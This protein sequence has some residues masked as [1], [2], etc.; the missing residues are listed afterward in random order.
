MR[1][2][3]LI[4]CALLSTAACT[5]ATTDPGTDPTPESVSADVA[6]GD[7]VAGESIDTA[8]DV[9][10]FTLHGPAGTMVEVRPRRIGGGTDTLEF[11]IGTAV[12]Q[13]LTPAD[14]QY[15]ARATTPVAIP[16][17]GGLSILF[18]G[19]DGST[20]HSTGGYAFTVVAI[21]S[22][23]EAHAGVI[24]LIDT[25][26]DESL[27]TPGDVDLFRVHLTGPGTGFGFTFAV[28]SSALG[29]GEAIAS[30]RDSATG[31]VFVSE[32]AS[33]GQTASSGIYGL[34][35]G[36]YQVRVSGAIT[37]RYRLVTTGFQLGPEI[38]PDTVL[39]GDTVSNETISPAADI[40]RFA[41]LGTA[42]QSVLI[43]FTGTGAA[44]PGD[45]VHLMFYPKN[46]PP[47]L[48]IIAPS[49]GTPLGA[50]TSARLELPSTMPYE[51]DIR[52]HSVG[53]YAFSIVPIP[54]TP[55]HVADTIVIGDTLVGESIDTPGD[56]DRFTVLG[57]P[58]Q[59][60]NLSS[61]ADTGAGILQVAVRDPVADTGVVA[62]HG[63]TP[64]T[65]TFPF[66]IPSGGKLEIAVEEYN[67]NERTCRDASCT[68]YFQY[69]GAYR[70]FLQP[71]D[72]LPEVASSTLVLG[73]TVT[74]EAIAPIGDFDDFFYTGTA[75]DTVSAVLHGSF[76]L[77]EANG[78]RLHVVDP[79]TG[80][81]IGSTS[82]GWGETNATGAIVLPHT[83][84]FLFQVLGND[85]TRDH[86]AYW[87]LVRPGS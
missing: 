19:H 23:P 74:N 15:G 67:S 8:G 27:D 66:R 28:D 80:A 13:L 79:A 41:Y 21:D 35:A 22:F 51:F 76:A 18:R 38:A 14:S 6:I 60:V 34:S 49:G 72:T 16:G 87:L 84:T 43:S 69:T 82:V 45:S 63:F 4:V 25:I 17:S 58:G 68:G 81:L 5:D 54:T 75:G 71:L 55:E 73:D 78:L 7:T 85:V 48:D 70:V 3:A 83:G 56:I 52:G 11:R 1:T 47:I 40:D 86:G 20:H 10:R 53:P 12:P 39:L 50:H 46:Q 29:S 62:T 61:S 65:P 42:R 30:L 36:T 64:S 24:A 33:S 44:V 59:F 57:T 31:E 2:T 37:G 77:N 9:D 26:T 32:E